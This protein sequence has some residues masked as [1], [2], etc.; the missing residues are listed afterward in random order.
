[1]RK[2]ISTSKFLVSWYFK[3]SQPQWTTSGLKQTS[4][5]LLFTLH[6]SH[7][8]TNS[9][10]NKKSVLTQFY[11]NKTYTN[12]KY[13]IFK[14]LIPFGITPVKKAPKARTCWYC[15]PFHQF[16]NTKLKKKKKSIQKELTKAIKNK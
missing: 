15:G 13:R 4:I 10:K 2:L 6:T 5:C 8:T 7:Q 3:S 14:E 12:I 9:Q 16:I 11:I 1:M